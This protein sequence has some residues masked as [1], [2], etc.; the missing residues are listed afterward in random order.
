V[1]KH[2]D[3][4][5]IKG[6]FKAY[7]VCLVSLLSLY[8]VIDL[9]MNLD[10]FTTR[11]PTLLAV[12]KH[13][14]SYYGYRLTKFFDQLCEPIVLL[15]AMFTVALMQRSNELIPLLSAGVSTRRVVL[16]VLVSA[17]VMLS[18]AVANAELVIPRI[19]GP[20]SLERDDPEGG[21]EL[22]V[23]GAYEPNRILINGLRG[24]RKGMLV[25]EF[26]CV[27]PGTVGGHLLEI[28]AAEARYRP[29]EAGNPLS[30]GWLLTGATPA[31]VEGWDRKEVLELIDPGKFFLHTQEVD[32][33][34]VTRQAK[35]FQFAS[36]LRLYEELQRP[37]T[38]R[39]PQMAVMFHMRLTRP[40][41]GMI[42]VFMGL[43]VILTDQ[44][45]HV[46]ISAGLCLVLCGLFFA[47]IFA[48]KQLG[49]TDIL[50]PAL[51]AWLP[52]LVFGPLAFVMFDAV[53]T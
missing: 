44:N 46:F 34:A 11:H 45:R 14:A 38:V 12:V 19:A 24:Q 37:D 33:D 13:I 52:V 18:L 6:Y 1:I 32:F 9:F 43:S 39:V 3:W 16:P 8:L 36:T 7:F 26:N 10:E 30:G 25:K 23:H 53:H 42:L 41:L 29:R 27:I 15:A 4:L 48:A 2:I 28:S 35:W 31:T 47:A 22:A 40:I 20:L 50:S 21:K 51:A 5:L 49:D 17:W